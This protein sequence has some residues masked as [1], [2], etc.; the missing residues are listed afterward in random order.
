MIYETTIKNPITKSKIP[1][2]D[3]AIN[4]Y[5]GCTMGCKYCFAQFIGAFKYKG[6]TWG[7]DVWIR[8]NIPEILPRSLSKISLGRFFLSSSCDSYQHIEKKTELTREILKI[9]ISRWTPIFIMTKSNLILRDIDLLKKSNDLLVNIT[10][11]TDSE[12]VRKT[13][14]PGASSIEDRLETVRRLKEAGINTGVF[15]GPVLPMNPEKLALKLKSIVDR[16]H[17]DPLNYPH[18]VSKIYRE[19]GWENWL[20]KEKY[21]WVRKTFEKI[22]G[23]ENLD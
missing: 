1:V 12:S 13:L 19:M 21:Y 14:E 17:L 2:A 18:Q 8:R 7:R 16:V 10:I 3:Y 22:F 15:V 9:L 11:T 20:Y 4:P 6:G 5:V 23:K